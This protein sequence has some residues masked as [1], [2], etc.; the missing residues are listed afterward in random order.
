MRPKAEHF[1]MLQDKRPDKKRMLVVKRLHYLGSIAQPWPCLSTRE[2]PH[3]EE[4]SAATEVFIRREVLIG[5]QVTVV[6]MTFHTRPDELF[7]WRL[8]TGDVTVIGVS[9]PVTVI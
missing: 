3:W 9:G 5:P 6:V 8:A 7:R 1:R 4:R 2:L